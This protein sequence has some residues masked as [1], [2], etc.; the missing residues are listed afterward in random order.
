MGL[1]PECQWRFPLL[2]DLG[3]I[4]KRIVSV[5][6]SGA[7]VFG[8]LALAPPALAVQP[9]AHV[10]A[11]QAASLLAAA[12]ESPRITVGA[13]KTTTTGKPNKSVRTTRLPALQFSSATNRKKFTTYAKESV[14][15]EL[16]TFN[17]KRQ[18][19][20]KGSKTA[21]FNALPGSM[22]VFKG[23][24]ASVTMRYSTYACSGTATSNAR[25]FTLDLKTGKKVGMSTF[26]SGNDITTKMAVNNNFGSSKRKCVVDL[27]PAAGNFPRPLAWDV[28]AKGIRFHYA[29]KPA[30]AVSCGTPDVLLPWTEVASP[31]SMKGAVK[32]RTYVRNLTSDKD[33]DTYWGEVIVT[34]VQGRKVTIFDAFLFSDGACLHGVR[35]GRSAIVSQFG[36]NNTKFNVKLLD[37][38]ANPR[39]DPAQFGQGWHE[40]TATE[41]RNIER[42]VGGPMFTAR[43]VCEP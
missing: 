21:T 10:Q 31:G 4:V 28:S 25:S 16:K 34:S 36:G 40:A 37:A 43:Q 17:A 35:S 18:G 6:A 7:L 38:S 3:G 33:Y 11:G 22:G 2:T 1:L 30:G 5:V 39:F 29:K 14:A 41:I 32:N 24:Y 12:A 27:N 9:A 20:C 13:K 26:V 42:T 8:T 19:K 23:R 15:A